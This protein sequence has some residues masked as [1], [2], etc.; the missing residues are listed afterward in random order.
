M[1]VGGYVLL[2]I[3]IHRAVFSSRRDD[4]CVLGRR[5]HELFGRSAAVESFA[6]CMQRGLKI[7]R[8]AGM[9]QVAVGK[10]RFDAL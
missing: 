2:L 4:V 1:D 9:K 3:E 5:E 7:Y 8:I 6:I 10:T